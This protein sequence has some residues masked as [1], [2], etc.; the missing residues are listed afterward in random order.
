MQGKKINNVIFKGTEVGFH[1]N[2]LHLL[3]QY[4]PIPTLI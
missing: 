4:F 2:H 3:P 1:H